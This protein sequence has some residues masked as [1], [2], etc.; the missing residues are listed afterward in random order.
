MTEPLPK[1]TTEEDRFE[2]PCRVWLPSQKR[3]LLVDLLRLPPEAMTLDVIAH[4]LATKARYCGHT[5]FPYSVALHSVLVADLMPVDVPLLLQM[6]ALMH[7]ASECFV[8][9]MIHPIKRVVP[10]F[11]AIEHQVERQVRA[12]YGLPAI[13]HELV[14]EADTKALW[15]EQHILQGKDYCPEAIALLQPEEVELAAALLCEERDWR[16]ARDIFTESYSFLLRD[17]AA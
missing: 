3:A 4:S 9:D 6:E 13:E 8:G 12:F 1:Y 11:K 15:L 5:P 14:K 2:I 10:A 17:M 7:D 16:I